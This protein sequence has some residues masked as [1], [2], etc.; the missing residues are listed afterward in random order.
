MAGIPADTFP[1]WNEE[2]ADLLAAW[3]SGG[4]THLERRSVE[5]VVR[6]LNGAGVRYLFVG[7]LAVVAHGFVRL[8]ADIDL[9]LDPERDALRRAIE[10]LSALGYR[11]RAPVEFSEFAD[12]SRRKE[13]ARDKGLR[14]FSVFSGQHKATEVDL[15]VETP[16]DFDRVFARA[17]RIEVAPGVEATFV[18][19]VDL[20]DMKRKAGRPQDLDDVEAL[21][22]LRDPERGGNG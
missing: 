4:A 14:V 11:P 21:E 6:A 20:I 16:F 5:A 2:A 13:W 22:S 1:A 18:G 3:Y 17:S 12:E 19:L 15:F 8:T 10:A 7:G 9:V